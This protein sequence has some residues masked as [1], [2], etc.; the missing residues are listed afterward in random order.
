M[1][2]ISYAIACAHIFVFS[3]IAHQFLKQKLYIF[4]IEIFWIETV[5][6]AVLICLMI[7]SMMRKRVTTMWWEVML[8]IIAFA[9][10]WIFGIALLPIPIAVLFASIITL[11]AFFWRSTYALDLFY[12]IGSLGIGLLAVWNFSA[13]IMM[14]MAMGVL[15]YDYYRYKEPGMAVLYF[16][17]RKSGLVP[18]VLIPVGIGGW[19]QKTKN[20]WKPG[21]GQVAGSLPFVALSGLCFH[22]LIRFSVWYFLF[23]CIFVIVLG[24]WKG[25]DERFR[26]RSWIFLGSSIIIFAGIYMIDLL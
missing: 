11:G 24:L 1:W 23:F 20:V 17:A 26:F 8:L 9:G 15:L 14:V 6:G 12:F 3:F 4:P 21:E 13:A 22:A 25:M 16:E 5:L 2:H 7:L 10:V 18:G 19:F